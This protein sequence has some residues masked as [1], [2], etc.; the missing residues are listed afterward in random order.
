MADCGRGH[1]RIHVADLSAEPAACTAAAATTVCPGG[2]ADGCAERSTATAV[3]E[4]TA[5][6]AS[7][8]TGA[9]VQG[10]GGSGLV[11]RDGERRHRAL[12]DGSPTAGFPGL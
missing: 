11:E 12:R 8:A 1:G 10:R 3:D 4:S 9:L 6:A 7:R 5:N 2:R